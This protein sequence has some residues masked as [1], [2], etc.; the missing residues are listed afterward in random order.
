MGVDGGDRCRQRYESRCSLCYLSGEN[1]PGARRQ[2]GWYLENGRSDPDD[3]RTVEKAGIKDRPT[4]SEIFNG[5]ANPPHLAFAEDVQD[6]IENI[7]L[8]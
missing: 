1:R 5:D 6:A 8:P 2:S 4:L 7:V 3:R